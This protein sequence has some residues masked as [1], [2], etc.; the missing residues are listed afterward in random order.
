MLK[1]EKKV[2]KHQNIKVL[3]RKIIGYKKYREYLN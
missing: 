3:K 1:N 2:N